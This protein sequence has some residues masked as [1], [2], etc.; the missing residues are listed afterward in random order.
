[1]QRYFKNTLDWPSDCTLPKTIEKWEIPFQSAAFRDFTWYTPEILKSGGFHIK[2][3]RFHMKLGGLHMKFGRFHMKLG[4]FHINSVDFMWNQTHF[5]WN[6]PEILKSTRFH[7]K[8]TG[9]HLNSSFATGWGWGL[10]PSV[11]LS[12]FKLKTNKIK[13]D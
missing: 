13:S 9:F 4:G 8:S 5:K 6:P 1:M 2:S 3:D 11:G 10:S 12:Y 7:V